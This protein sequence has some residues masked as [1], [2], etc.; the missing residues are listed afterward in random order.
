MTARNTIINTDVSFTCAGEEIRK[1]GQLNSSTETFN[2]LNEQHAATIADLKPDRYVTE[3]AEL[4]DLEVA[5][6]NLE[7]IELDVGGQLTSRSSEV[8]I[9]TGCSS[10][11]SQ[12]MD[13]ARRSRVRRG[14]CGS[15][16]QGTCALAVTLPLQY[17][18]PH[19]LEADKTV[20][21]LD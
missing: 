4:N 14:S 15:D 11:R 9:N 19:H 18:C 6:I 3:D 8:T 21:S 13:T 5:A 10:Q 7:S 16:C 20:Q 1:G 17:P 2:R 12:P